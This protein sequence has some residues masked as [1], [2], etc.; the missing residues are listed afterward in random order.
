MLHLFLNK[1]LVLLLL[2][3]NQLFKM[4]KAFEYPNRLFDSNQLF[5]IFKN[6]IKFSEVIVSLITKLIQDPFEQMTITILTDSLKHTFL[7]SIGVPLNPQKYL[8]MKLLLIDDS[9]TLINNVSF[10]IYFENFTAKRLL[11]QLVSQFQYFK[12]LILLS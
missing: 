6:H 7:V 3:I 11:I 1:D 10:V 5:I 4:I 2:W 9:S 8:S 12:A